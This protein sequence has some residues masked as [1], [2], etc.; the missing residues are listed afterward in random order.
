[1]ISEGM[2]ATRDVNHT[3]TRESRLPELA[4]MTGTCCTTE[5]TVVSRGTFPPR[6]FSQKKQS[7]GPCQQR[8]CRGTIPQQGAAA[9]A[10][11]GSSATKHRRGGDKNWYKQGTELTHYLQP[12]T[13]IPSRR[14]LLTSPPTDSA[15]S[16]PNCRGKGDGGGRNVSVFHHVCKL[17]QDENGAQ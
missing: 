13:H 11:Y 12:H 16:T 17:L 9:Q 6:N 10:G 3:C 8:R 14:N 1:V 2:L 7:H 4:C 5:G 15:S